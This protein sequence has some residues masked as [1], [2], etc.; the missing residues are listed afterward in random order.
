MSRRKREKEMPHTTNKR[1]KMSGPREHIKDPCHNCQ[2]FLD[3]SQ[4]SPDVTCLHIQIHEKYK[5][6]LKIHIENLYSHGSSSVVLKFEGKNVIPAVHD[7]IR[8]TE[9]HLKRLDSTAVDKGLRY[10]VEGKKLSGS[11]VMLIDI[12][13]AVCARCTSEVRKDATG[14]VLSMHMDIAAVNSKSKKQKKENPNLDDERRAIMNGF[15]RNVCAL[16]NVSGGGSIIVHFLGKDTEDPGTYIGGFDE[17]VNTKLNQLLPPGELFVNNFKRKLL[18]GRGYVIKFDVAS[19]R[20]LSTVDMKTKLPLDDCLLELDLP[21]LRTF[22]R[23]LSPRCQQERNKQQLQQQRDND[24]DDL[25]ESR[26]VQLKRF[27]PV[28][29]DV[30]HTNAADI[31]WDNLKLGENISAFAKLEEGGTY[32]CGIAEEV[33]EL[34]RYQTKYSETRGIP[35]PNGPTGNVEAFLKEKIE[36]EMVAVTEHFDVDKMQN[37]SKSVNIKAEPHKGRVILVVHVPAYRGLLFFDKCGPVSYRY[38][39][40]VEI[41]R[42]LELDEWCDKIKQYTN[43]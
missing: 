6:L 38:D 18:K 5:D 34:K 23:T 36:K 29:P 27:P 3:K 32:Y 22:M 11:N 31:I 40:T 35:L 42:R 7:V 13:C 21:S 24:L 14:Q 41:V 16:Q 30:S 26:H 12:S 8:T 25:H 20:T 33:R 1:P 19:S 2:G 37:Y 9:E 17:M 43:M 15:I 10:T 28:G 39:D 4:S